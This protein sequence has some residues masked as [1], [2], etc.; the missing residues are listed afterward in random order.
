MSPRHDS[1][2]RTPLIQDR[3]HPQP[4]DDSVNGEPIVSQDHGKF[5]YYLQ[6]FWILLKSSIPVVLAYSL[7]NSIQTGSVLIVGRI[8]ADALAVS[9]FSFMFAQVTAYCVAL[10]GTTAIDT[11]GSAVF[12]AS[13]DPRDVGIILQRAFIVLT[14]FYIPIV[15]LWI[16]SEPIFLALGQEDFVARDSA[17]FLM[18]LIP[19]AW[20]YIGFEAVKKLL[21]ACGMSAHTRCQVMIAKV[22]WQISIRLEQL[23]FSSLVLL[24]RCSTT[25]LCIHSISAYWGHQLLHR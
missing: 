12:T 1:D 2:E 21:Q 18:L 22:D 16:F 7:Q 20:A 8:S 24:M 14:A 3:N 23:Y 10:G 13:K 9:S 11:L 4:S 19:G 15:M 6:E 5:S 25:Y 17:K